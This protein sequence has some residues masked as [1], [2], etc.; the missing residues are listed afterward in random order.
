[1]SLQ[2][3]VT[4]DA[5]C[6]LLVTRPPACSSTTEAMAASAYSSSIGQRLFKKSRQAHRETQQRHDVTVGSPAVSTLP[7][8]SGRNLHTQTGPP[9]CTIDSPE[10][11]HCETLTTSKASNCYG[12]DFCLALSSSHL[13]YLIFTN[14]CCYPHIHQCM[15]YSLQHFYKICTRR[16][17]FKNTHETHYTWN[18]CTLPQLDSSQIMCNYFCW[19]QRL[20]LLLVLLLLITGNICLTSCAGLW[21]WPHQC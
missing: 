6:P 19:L 11:Q 12:N 5:C 2:C 4:G 20:L 21:P 13:F 9:S 8:L 14:L 10:T 1:M 7:V 17:F 16:D 15:F 3:D 18:T